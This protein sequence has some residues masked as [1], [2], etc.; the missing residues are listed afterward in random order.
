MELA[1]TVYAGIMD[2]MFWKFSL[3]KKTRTSIFLRRIWVPCPGF[4][5][6]SFKAP[7]LLM[8]R[9]W[10]VLSSTEDAGRTSQEP[11]WECLSNAVNLKGAVRSY[12][13]VPN[14][15][16]INVL[17]DTWSL[18]FFCS[19]LQVCYLS[20]ETQCFQV[21]DFWLI[22]VSENKFPGRQG[23]TYD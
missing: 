19:I 6:P 17:P 9:K 15:V 16:M 13:R 21:K 4:L 22:L 12:Y 20:Y 8:Q 7:T 5:W 14:A 1:S 11:C 3:I 10:S 23:C 2:F 18:P